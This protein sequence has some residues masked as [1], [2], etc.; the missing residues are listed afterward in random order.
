VVWCARSARAR[1]TR[2]G[3]TSGRS[4]IIED[5][6]FRGAELTGLYQ[7]YHREPHHLDIELGADFVRAELRDT[8]EP[9]PRIPPRRYRLGFHYQ[10]AK[11]SA[12]VEGI[13]ADRQDRVSELEEP[14]PG[15]NLLNATVGY[16]LFAGN[17]I[18]DV[19]LRGTNLTDEV[20]FS[21]VSFLKD[22]APLPG[23]NLSLALRVAF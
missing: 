5:A 22:V 13:R 3:G 19:L 11:L 2:N 18:Y 14:T 8:G 21:H 12:R 4:R 7:L 10:G 15:Y 6:E 23:R 1:R 20:A 16:R 17:V 9:L